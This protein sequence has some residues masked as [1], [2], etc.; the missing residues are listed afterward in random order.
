VFYLIEHMIA[1][2]VELGLSPDHAALLAKQTL[3][4]SA[5]M[6]KTSADSP[7]ELR[8]KV[9]SPNGTTQAAI[10]SMD[11]AGVG[12]AVRKAIEAACKRSVELREAAS[13]PRG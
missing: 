3:L 11:A 13:P 1:A 10:E 4:G 7:A 9:T 6:A 5:T 12:T 8:R 2:G